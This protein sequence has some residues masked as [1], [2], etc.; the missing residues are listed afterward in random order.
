MYSD[1]NYKKAHLVDFR[2]VLFRLEKETTTNER[3]Y[4]IKVLKECI[5]KC[6]E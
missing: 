1:K 5:A 2:N 3:D 4:R 6:S